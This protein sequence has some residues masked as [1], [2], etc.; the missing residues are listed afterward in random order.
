MIILINKSY[1]ACFFGRWIEGGFDF[2]CHSNQEVET[3]WDGLLLTFSWDLFRQG[4][5][6]HKPCY[7]VTFSQESCSL[8]KAF[9]CKTGK[10]YSLS[11]SHWSLCERSDTQ[12]VSLAQRTQQGLTMLRNMEKA[13][14]VLLSIKRVQPNLTFWS[15]RLK[16]SPERAEICLEWKQRKCSACLGMNETDN[17]FQHHFQKPSAIIHNLGL[18]IKNWN[19]IKTQS[20]ALFRI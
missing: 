13:T 3:N 15:S 16:D 2:L 18:Q 6:L 7:S 9:K 12:T 5:A 20:L 1:K 8:K 4:T 19:T 10:N 14:R 17:N 11:I